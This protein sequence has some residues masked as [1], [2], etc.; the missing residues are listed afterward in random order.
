VR[1]RVGKGTRKKVGRKNPWQVKQD[2]EIQKSKEKEKRDNPFRALP[3]KK[4]PGVP[5]KNK[6]VQWWK[7]PEKGL[8]WWS[9]QKL[10]EDTTER[11][12]PWRVERGY[13]TMKGGRGGLKFLPRGCS[14]GGDP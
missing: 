2:R 9:A 5:G 10:V 14:G 7:K 13:R 6:K 12:V 3:R 1:T 4:R 8:F 11:G